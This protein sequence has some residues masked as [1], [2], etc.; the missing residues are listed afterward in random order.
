MKSS[1]TLIFVLLMVPRV[2]CEETTWKD[3]HI[4]TKNTASI[5]TLLP[6]SG[7][8]PSSFNLM[9]YQ[10]EGKWMVRVNSKCEITINEKNVRPRCRELFITAQKRERNACK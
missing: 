6:F 1:V 3:F 9:E 7:I 8:D 2:F 4:N 5:L 10:C